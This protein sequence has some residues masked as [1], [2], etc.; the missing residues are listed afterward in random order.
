MKQLFL[1]LLLIST[2]LST[3]AQ[4]ID[5]YGGVNYL[6]DSNTTFSYKN[7][8]PQSMYFVQGMPTPI[9]YN[10]SWTTVVKTKTKG[11]IFAQTGVQLSWN[12]GKKV[13]FHSGL[14]LNGKA[15]SVQNSSKIIDYDLVRLFNDEIIDTIEHQDFQVSITNETVHMKCIYMYIPFGFQYDLSHKISIG[16][17]SFIQMPLWSL[18]SYY[19]KNYY[20]N[21]LTKKTIPNEAPL[22]YPNYG[23][24]CSATYQMGKWGIKLGIQQQ[25][26]NLFFTKNI[27]PQSNYY[28]KYLPTQMCLSLKYRIK[29]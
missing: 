25:L 15:F 2:S 1:L 14:E 28:N 27:N 26:N 5:V 13:Y 11:G 24:S 10:E 8:N 6:F 17:G 18:S 9:I 4:Q 22:R 7:E 20:S 3:F 19:S 29:N 21:N 23:L 12:L 16:A